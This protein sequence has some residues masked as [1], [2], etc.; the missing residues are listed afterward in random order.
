MWWYRNNLKL[1]ALPSRLWVFWPPSFVTSRFGELG[2]ALEREGAIGIPLGTGFE[3][4]CSTA[5]PPPPSAA[6]RPARW[7]EELIAIKGERPYL[8]AKIAT[9]LLE[10]GRQD[11][12]M[13]QQEDR[14]QPQPARPLPDPLV[15]LRLLRAC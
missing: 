13:A 3:L 8:R 5:A 12:A 10:D 2:Q 1:D 11:E 14:R 6:P 7:W 4:T 9:L 15:L